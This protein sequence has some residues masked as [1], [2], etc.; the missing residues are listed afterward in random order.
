[1]K[2]IVKVGTNNLTAAKGEA[3]LLEIKKKFED[4]GFFEEEDRV[5]Y[6]GVGG[7]FD[8]EIVSIV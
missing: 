8:F 1:M 7:S 3:R 5:V 6:V 2:Y 4:V